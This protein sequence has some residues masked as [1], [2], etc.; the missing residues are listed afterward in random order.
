MCVAS[1]LKPIMPDEQSQII[2]NILQ[3]LDHTDM[4]YLLGD[5]CAIR[6]WDPQVT[7]GN[8]S[9]SGDLIA[10]SFIPAP[11]SIA[12]FIAGGADLTSEQLQKFAKQSN[13][14]RLTV[15]TRDYVNRTEFEGEIDERIRFLSDDDLVREILITSTIDILGS[16]LP[17]DSPYQDELAQWMDE[18]Q[19]I[20]QQEST[21]SDEPVPVEDTDKSTENNGSASDMATD[22]TDYQTAETIP[23]QA[24]DSIGAEC[25]FYGMEYLGHDYVP[26]EEEP[27][28][29]IAFEVFAKEY[30][31]EI[32]PNKFSLYSHDGFSYDGAK[33]WRIEWMTSVLEKLSHPWAGSIK[34]I[35]AGGRIKFLAFIPT[36][37]PVEPKKIRYSSNYYGLFTLSDEQI[38]TQL[39][40]EI[41]TEVSTEMALDTTGRKKEFLGLPDEVQ[42]SVLDL[43]PVDELS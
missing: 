24:A 14:D 18:N 13:E 21:V 5:L 11:E 15:V 43:V 19:E 4:V 29:L 40:K 1:N 17:D 25:Q 9:T 31:I 16:Y 27:A 36:S 26:H 7:I 41:G 6:G 35:P 28:M 22:Q 37:E 20:P 39:G 33:T 34:T 8:T 12:L 2:L 10:R 30:D 23:E 32:R 3:E 42:Q 38:K